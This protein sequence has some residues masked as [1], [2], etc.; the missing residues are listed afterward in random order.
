MEKI[1]IENMQNNKKSSSFKK[2]GI[3]F[4]S[5][6]LVI[7]AVVAFTITGIDKTSYAVEPTVE[8][9]TTGAQ[10]TVTVYKGTQ[11]AAGTESSYISLYSDSASNPVYCVEHDLPYIVGAEYTNSGDEIDSVL[12]YLLLNGQNILSGRKDESQFI[13]QTAVFLHEYSVGR[14]NNTNFKNFYDAFNASGFKIDK[15]ALD[16]VEVTNTGAIVYSEKIKNLLA[17]AKEFGHSGFDISLSSNLKF[18]VVKI[19]ETEYYKSNVASITSKA[20]EYILN[21]NVSLGSNAP[22]NAKIVN[23]DNEEIKSALAKGEGFYILIPKDSVTEES[24][25]VDV[26]VEAVFSDCV[27]KTDCDGK[28]LSGYYYVTTE[29]EDGK[30]GQKLIVPA[31]ISKTAADRGTYTLVPDTALSTSQTVYFVGLIILVGGLGVI[32]ANVKPKEEK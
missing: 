26:N 1:Y 6:I 24:T 5:I 31:R 11:P 19:G 27:G 14:S 10:K 20:S 22:K 32:Y 15:I 4:S 9:I 21:Y 30:V 28:I 2:Y 16:G 3:A 8:K 7:I 12:T 25:S 23:K 17:Q 18:E 13:T 29:V